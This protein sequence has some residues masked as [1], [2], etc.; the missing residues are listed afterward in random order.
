MVKIH[1]GNCLLTAK[2]HVTMMKNYAKMMKSA[3]S[4]IM[5]TARAKMPRG[6]KTA[7]MR[8]DRA[9]K[10]PHA[11]MAGSKTVPV[12]V[13]NRASTNATKMAHVSRPKIAKMALTKAQANV[14]APINAN[15][16]ATRQGRRVPVLHPVLVDATTS[17]RNAPAKRVVSKALHATRA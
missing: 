2:A 4:A 7:I 13:Q 17:D 16:A 12:C 3:K 8:M 6:A 14:N 10:T 9:S 11:S 1:F 15:M 5:M